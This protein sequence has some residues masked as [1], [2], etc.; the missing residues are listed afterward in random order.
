[1][2]F[3]G[4][5]RDDFCFEANGVDLRTYGSR[6]QQRTA[7]LALKLAETQFMLQETGHQPI[8]LLDE[9]MAELDRYR[10]R[11]LLQTVNGVQQ[12]VLTTTKWDVFGE[13]FLSGALCLRVQ[14]GRIQIV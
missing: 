11:H 9:V 6:G 7:V 1:M 12:A 4:P 10:Q 3:L 2:T 13:E 14:E 5:H 8:L